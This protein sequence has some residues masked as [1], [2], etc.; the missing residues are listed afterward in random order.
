MK[1]SVTVLTPMVRRGLVYTTTLVL[2]SLTVL[3]PA[4]RNSNNSSTDSAS[5]K[6]VAKGDLPIAYVKRPV[7]TIGNPTDGV[8]FQAGGDLY[9]RKLSSPSAEE[10]NLTS[11]YTQGQGDV[12]DPEVSFD[13]TKLLF[14]MKG[15][16]DPTWDIWEYTIAS[17]SLSRVMQDAA[18]A[19]LGDDVDPAYL[20]DG[21]IVFASDRQEKTK[22]L[23]AADNVEPYSY[24]DEYEREASIVLHVMN[25][26]GTN[27][28]Q[29]SFNQ[30]HDRNPVVLQ[31]GEIMYSRWD[32]VGERNQF[33][34]FFTNPDGTNLFVLYGAHSPGNSFLHPREMQ[35]G[36]IVS[37]LMPLSGTSEGGALV[38]IDVANYSE[39]D[40]PAPGVN[41]AL[42]GQQQTTLSEIPLERGLSASGRYATPYPLWD[43]TER[44]L[45]SWTPSQPTVSTNAITRAEEMVEGAPVYGVYM[46]DLNTKSVRP[47]ALAPAGYA[48]TDAVAI[49]PRPLPNIVS[50]KLLSA[51]LATEGMGILNVKSVYDTDQRGRMGQ[52]VLAAGES[53]PMITAPSG[54]GRT[55]VADIAKL[56]DGLQTNAAQRPARFVRITKAVPTPPGLSREAI[57][58][59]EFEM[60]QILGY[61]EIEPDGSFKIK[62]PAD[63]PLAISVIDAQGRS[64]TP[65][66][67][68]VQ[69]RPGETRT[70]NGCHSPRRGNALNVEPIA[71]QHQDLFGTSDIGM[72]HVHPGVS[73]SGLLRATDADGNN[74][75]YSIVTPPSQ[76]TVVITNSRTGEFIYTA[77]ANAA[78]GTDFF[79]FKANDGV[80]DSNIATTLI[81]INEPP[82]ATA[83]ESMAETRTRHF[84]QTQLL[85]ADVLYSD[86]WG[87]RPN[88]CI[89]IRYVG[90]RDC[91]GTLLPSEDLTTPVP[92]SGIIN[93]PDHI[94][95][96]WAKN[97]G[98]NTC[99]N[100]H[101]S[102]D[103][104]NAASVGLDLRN[105]ASATGRSNSYESL[106]VG[107]PI[108]DASGQPILDID[109]DVVKVRRETPLVSTGHAR[110]SYVVEKLFEQELLATRNLTSTVN[111]AGFLNRAEK[112]LLTEWIDLGG[113]Y[114]NDPFAADAN[115]DGIK[116]MTETRS[117]AGQLDENVFAQAV[118][119]VLARRCASCHQPFGAGS[120]TTPNASFQASRFVLTGTAGDFSAVA[121]MVNDLTNP[122][123]SYLLARPSSS[124]TPPALVHPTVASVNNRQVPV[125]SPTNPADPQTAADYQIIFGWMDAARVASGL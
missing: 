20:P 54:D 3:L 79:T 109:D 110:G 35:N 1:L 107:K 57:G 23:M 7:G 114:Y 121:S 26:D 22:L 115:G 46:L 59:T 98:A 62:V 27:I 15:P 2:L 90:N 93:Y 24:H 89:G 29:I 38:L 11:R 95:P 65:H 81:N 42:G 10:I 123:A 73:V 72:V 67:S 21:R 8:T 5:A 55:Q 37:S 94:E 76:G 44:V 85:Q 30:S 111:H 84:P 6:S 75:T 63:I 125:L 17:G 9:L 82:F 88:P 71:G 102:A 96:L 56:K 97:R 39:H 83:G 104:N 100:C 69:V 18:T 91:S 116:N 105:T 25:S 80:V 86:V 33:S 60:Q 14:T 78:I 58:E 119:P 34:I 118:Q 32:H 120:L 92:N 68:W 49:M 40:E 4:C 41:A 87:A 64:F 122:A 45:V 106:L 28:K 48:I 51:G 101:N 112:R 74:L 43:G 52:A 31:S 77:N 53:I 47:V 16:N 50:D 12:S 61:A 103:S 66:T 124:G 19:N 117:F 99:V 70:C 108:L 36:K 13:G 113:Q